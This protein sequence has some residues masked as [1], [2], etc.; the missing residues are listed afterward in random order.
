MHNK[1]QAFICDQNSTYKF[2]GRFTTTTHRAGGILTFKDDK[3]VGGRPHTD[4]IIIVRALLLQSWYG[5]SDQELEFQVNDRLSFRNF[6]GFPDNV[7]DFSTIWRIRERLQ[8]GGI[9][10][11]IWEELQKQLDQKG[12]TIQKGVIQDASFIEADLGRRTFVKTLARVKI[13][14]VFKCFGFNSYQLVTLE[15]KNLAKAFKI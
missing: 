2:S 11:K 1:C 4:E 3:E 9:E 14:E 5:L 10:A 15:K 6:L 12:Y 8:K 13:K 7:P